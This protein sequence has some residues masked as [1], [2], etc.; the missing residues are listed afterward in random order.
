MME[1]IYSIVVL[2]VILYV[3]ASLYRL[4]QTGVLSYRRANQDRGYIEAHKTGEHHAIGD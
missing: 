4:A 3:S 2:A 1:V